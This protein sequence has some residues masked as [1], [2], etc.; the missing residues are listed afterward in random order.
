MSEIET[1]FSQH[2]VATEEDDASSSSH[3]FPSS[4]FHFLASLSSSPP[5]PPKPPDDS[6]YQDATLSTCLDNLHLG[7]GTHFK[8]EEWE[9]ITKEKSSHNGRIY[10]EG[11]S[12]FSANTPP[13]APVRGDMRA[14]SHYTTPEGNITP[15][16]DRCNVTPE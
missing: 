7:G 5:L 9:N 13:V 10:L 8:E 3:D 1:N 16:E 4:D 14:P 6:M 2:F 15:A 12:L 11:S